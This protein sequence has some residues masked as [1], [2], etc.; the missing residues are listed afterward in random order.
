MKNKENPVRAGRLFHDYQEEKK[1]LMTGDATDA[2]LMGLSW[3]FKMAVKENS[4]DPDV[5]T[6]K[7]S[8][9]KFVEH[10]LDNVLQSMDPVSPHFRRDLV[11]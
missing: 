5:T 6:W 7:S 3:R 11:K 4:D 8:W 2:D 10:A 9:V 1:R